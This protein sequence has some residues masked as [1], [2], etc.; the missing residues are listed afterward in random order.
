MKRTLASASTKMIRVG[1]DPCSIEKSGQKAASSSCGTTSLSWRSSRYCTTR[2][3]S[4][5]AGVVGSAGR[6][7]RWVGTV[8]N[9]LD[10]PVL[11]KM[12]S[13]TTTE[14]LWTPV[15]P[16]PA[17]ILNDPK[18]SWP[19]DKELAPYIRACLNKVDFEN[20][21]IAKRDT[22]FSLC[23]LGTGSG[24]G[25]ISRSNAAT[26]IKK[27]GRCYLVD[28]GEG[29]QRQFLM[30]R[31][32]IRDI[33]KIFITHMHGDHIFGLPGLL[34]FLQVAN[35]DANH[36]RNIEIFGPVGLYNF[37]TASLT[38]SGTEIKK[39]KV[40]VFEL[41]GG[42][43]RSMR[44]GANRKTFLDF[45]QRGI[46][47]HIIP[48]NADGTFTLC[49]P[50]EIT[51]R[52]LAE[53]LAS[54]PRGLLIQAAEIEHV[55]TLQCFGYTFQEPFTQP[56]A[57]DLV[58]TE[59]AGITLHEHFR[60]LKSGFSVRIGDRE[61]RADDVCLTPPPQPRKATILGDCAFVPP[62]MERLALDSDILVHEATLT[63]LDKGRK[64]TLG[65]HSTAAEA[66]MFANKCRA[67]VL[68][69]THISAKLDAAENCIQEANKAIWKH[70]TTVQ[71]AFDHME[72]M[73]PR[74]GFRLKQLLTKD[75]VN[76]E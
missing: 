71:L 11:P 68:V 62:V 33:E 13:T 37:L 8:P 23:T 47:R 19:M 55:P 44:S 48:Q 7:R 72:I 4:S 30:S 10:S 67:K 74:G 18:L 5:A 53:R 56:R 40:N 32:N 12:D 20:E 52:E 25:S 43:Q 14:T 22:E 24:A 64:V 1:R 73:V 17:S 42:T 54:K 3:S 36:P 34:L 66:A 9:Y 21:E 70:Q 46:N 69:L 63:M 50:T 26:L 39:L 38:L 60:E 35:K 2:P 76:A 51:T 65:G 49:E 15:P 28:C 31:M 45:K 75:F 41:H 59:A 16:L 61:V 57:L 29:I 58:K 27:G 6:Q